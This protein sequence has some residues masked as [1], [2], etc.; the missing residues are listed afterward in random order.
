[1]NEQNEVQQV[2]VPEWIDHPLVGQYIYRVRAND[3][4]ADTPC[5]ALTTQSI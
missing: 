3:L 5:A 1:M 2:K 4:V